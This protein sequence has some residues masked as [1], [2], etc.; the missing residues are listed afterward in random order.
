MVTKALERVEKDAGKKL[1]NLL[2]SAQ[3][4][5]V[6]VEVTAAAWLYTE[7]K[8]DWRLYIVTPLVDQKGRLFVNLVVFDSM[9]AD[10]VLKDFVRRVEMVGL[11]DRYA[12]WLKMMRPVGGPAKL[13]DIQTESSKSESGIEASYIYLST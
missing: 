8:N 11:K 5:E 12:E 4:T 7:R 6:P 2:R 1:V 10:E 9:L 3:G 13:G